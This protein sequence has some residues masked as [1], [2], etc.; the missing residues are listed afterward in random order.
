MFL[1][2]VSLST[3]PNSVYYLQYIHVSSLEK[4]SYIQNK[5]KQCTAV[6]RGTILATNLHR[7]YL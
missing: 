7:F 2:W 6:D 5:P 4:H 1:S 3:S